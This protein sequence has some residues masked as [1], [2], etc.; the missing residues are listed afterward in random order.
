MRGHHDIIAKLFNVHSSYR[1]NANNIIKML[2]YKMEKE[3]NFIKVFILALTTYITKTKDLKTAQL[4]GSMISNIQ[5][6]LLTS[7]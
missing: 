7:K 3:P 2:S 5:R 1:G 4:L 6:D